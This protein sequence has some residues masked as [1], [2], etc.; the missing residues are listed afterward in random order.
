MAS[1]DLDQQNI[2]GYKPLWLTPEAKVRSDLLYTYDTQR[3]IGPFDVKKRTLI[4]PFIECINF[5]IIFFC[6]FYKKND[7]ITLNVICI[8]QLTKSK[9][10]LTVIDNN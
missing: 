6:L 5:K 2:T 8:K 10:T 3:L 4:K 9:R 7:P 1:K